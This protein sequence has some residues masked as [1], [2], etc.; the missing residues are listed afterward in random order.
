MKGKKSKSKTCK[1]KV[2][3]HLKKDIKEQKKG[4][5]EDKILKRELNK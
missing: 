5:T 2:L 1:T 3:R 4:I